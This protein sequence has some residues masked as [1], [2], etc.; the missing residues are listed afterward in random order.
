[1]SKIRILIRISYEFWRMSRM[2][3]RAPLSRTLLNVGLGLAFVL[4]FCEYLIYYVVLIQ[5]SPCYAFTHHVEIY[6]TREH[7]ISV[8][9]ENSEVAAW[10]LLL[11][12]MARSGHSQGG[13][14]SAW[15]SNRPACQSYV[16][17][18]HPLVGFQGG[19]LVRQTEEVCIAK[20]VIFRLHCP[21]E[22]KIF[23]SYSINSKILLTIV[24]YILSI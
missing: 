21:G 6:T 9:E 8:L 5:V 12:R 23:I 19:P 1:M 13:P 16:Y 20:P 7:I 2:Y 15:G 3:L 17:S 10:F 14:R 22:N 24:R 4:L 18:G 11:V